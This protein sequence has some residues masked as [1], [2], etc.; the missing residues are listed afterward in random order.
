MSDSVQTHEE[1]LGELHQQLMRTG[2]DGESDDHD[3][4]LTF[5]LKGI[6]YGVDILGIKEIIEYGQV[7]KIPMAPAYIRGVI[8][9]RGNV[10]PIVD[11]SVRLGKDRIEENKKTCIIIL[12]ME[13]DGDIMVLGFVVDSVNEVI[14]IVQD[15]V[16]ATPTFGMDIRTDFVAGMG[17]VNE[18]FVVIL[19][20]EKV[21]SIKEL[22]EFFEIVA[23]D[24]D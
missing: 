5:E 12:E 16:E 20:L 18:N 7:T 22:S 9:L 23:E 21:L 19:E 4:Y 10:V 15:S 24:Q 14:D 1:Q 3:K 17:R 8:N 11:L 6:T 13:Q 2:A